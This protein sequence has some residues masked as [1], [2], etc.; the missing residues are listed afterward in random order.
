MVSTLTI[1]V[2]G[3][4]CSDR[5]SKWQI[6]ERIIDKKPFNMSGNDD[7]LHILE[8]HGREFLN[9]FSQPQSGGKKRKRRELEESRIDWEKSDEW[10]GF[11]TVTARDAASD[12]DDLGGKVNDN[13][14]HY[15]FCVGVLLTFD[16][17]LD[18]AFSS[19][20]TSTR[21]PAVV[22]FSESKLGSTSTLRSTKARGSS[23]MV[24]DSIFFD[25]QYRS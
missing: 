10:Q 22:I 13:G 24:R 20:S 14:T 15:Q 6:A 4:T 8:A 18:H 19:E 25:S 11:G 9:S 16:R 21:A 1:R 12:N 2:T 17:C 23:F 5:Y 3:C 7:L